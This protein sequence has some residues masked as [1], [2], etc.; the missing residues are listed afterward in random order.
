MITHLA[1]WDGFSLTSI[2]HV[3][4]HWSV[5]FM[6][7]GADHPSASYPD[8]AGPLEHFD[9]WDIHTRETNPPSSA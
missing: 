1:V 3:V 7:A 8:D 5:A 4:M 2:E 9:R 6:N